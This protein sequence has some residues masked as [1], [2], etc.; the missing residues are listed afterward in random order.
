V[1]AIRAGRLFDAKAGRML[2]NQVI[3]ITGDK[4]TRRRPNLQI[5]A[6]ATTIDLSRATV[7]PGMVD[8]H[9]HLSG[10]SVS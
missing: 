2:T 10:R 5:P 4:I 7:L 6:G 8:G 3:L 1:V 9:L